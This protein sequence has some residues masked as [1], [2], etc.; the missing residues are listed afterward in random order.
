M[1]RVLSVLIFVFQRSYHDSIRWERV[2]AFWEHNP[3]CDLLY[4]YVYRRQRGLGRPSVTW[5]LEYVPCARNRCSW[6]GEVKSLHRL[7]PVTSDPWRWE[8]RYFPKR[9]FP[10][11]QMIV[12]ED[13]IRFTRH[14]AF[15]SYNFLFIPNT[16]FNRN[17][18]NSFRPRTCKLTDTACSLCVHYI[19][20]VEGKHI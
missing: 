4:I 5:Y 20:L 9:W 15:K 14:E 7:L 16:K 3:L 11:T 10:S 8:Q 17:P 6:L 2:A 1:A 13:F 18:F 12:T 19:H